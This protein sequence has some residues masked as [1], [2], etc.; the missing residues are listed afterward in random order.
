MSALMENGTIEPLAVWPGVLVRAVHGERLT[1]AIA[2]LA[3]DVL[4]PAHQHPNEQ[5]GVVV[6]GSAKFTTDGD[7]RNLS[8]GSV[9]RFFA[10]VPH[11][12]QAGPSGAVFIEC[13]A[14]GRS[15]WMKLKP[16]PVAK[17]GWPTS[18]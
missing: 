8:A 11:E 14:P 13:F 12:V 17:P 4:V 10:N 3:P 1:V 6:A 18:G 2:E 5:L 15:D 9:Y 16:E 7:S